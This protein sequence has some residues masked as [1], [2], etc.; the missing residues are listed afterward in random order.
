[1]SKAAQDFGLRNIGSFEEDDDEQGE[2]YDD[3]GYRFREIENYVDARYLAMNGSFK[4]IILLI[5]EGYLTAD[6]VIDEESGF[7]IMHLIAHFGKVKALQTLVG[8]LHADVNLADASGQ[9]PI[10]LAALSGEI[11]I[12][13]YLASLSRPHSVSLNHPL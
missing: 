13:R 8:R 10:H 2:E 1:M 7:R 11:E 12:L 6:M 4:P 9:T 3:E 5:A